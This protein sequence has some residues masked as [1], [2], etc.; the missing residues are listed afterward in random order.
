MNNDQNFVYSE[1][2]KLNVKKWILIPMGIAVLIIAVILI[3][4]MLYFY[5]KEG[6]VTGDDSMPLSTLLIIVAGGASVP[7]L[8]IILIRMRMKLILGVNQKTLFY[9]YK[10]LSTKVESI[11]WDQLVSVEAKKYPYPATRP[12]IQ[13]WYSISNFTGYVM[14]LDYMGI[15][16]VL[17]NGKKIFFTSN[18]TDELLKAIQKLEPGIQIIK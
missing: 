7:A 3:V 5:F 8:L 17:K 1:E 9:S 2:Q 15:E 6:N 14:N 4:P 10:A 18:Q 13:K 11:S 16:L 12:G